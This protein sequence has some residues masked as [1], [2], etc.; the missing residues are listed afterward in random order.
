MRA[1]VIFL[2]GAAGLLA[3]STK[4][5]AEII[6]LKNGRTISADHVRQ[7][8]AHLEYEIGEESFA[9]LNS[10]VDHVEAGTLPEYAATN[11]AGALPN[12]PVFTPPEGVGN[13]ADLA[14]KI[15]QHG[16]VDSEALAQLDDGNPGTAAAGYYL[17]GKNEFEHGNFSRSSLQLR[18]GATL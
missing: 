1:F 11:S 12:I 2:L 7:E 8:G 16:V 15:I 18:A 14:D 9:I 10:S 4:A 17:A 13:N 3:V 5:P 6:H